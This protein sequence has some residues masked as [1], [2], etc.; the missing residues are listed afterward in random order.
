METILMQNVCTNF[1]ADI[2]CENQVKICDMSFL[3]LLSSLDLKNYSEYSRL[4]FL[5]IALAPDFFHEKNRLILR[6]KNQEFEI[7]FNINYEEFKNADKNQALKMLAEACLTATD[8][9]LAK[10]KD[11]RA[12]DFREDLLKIF[13][14]AGLTD[15]DLTG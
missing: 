2:S 4:T 8:Q 9:F 15:A 3:R 13:S 1:I 7:R 5:F 14:A 11:F 10:R 6:K 12:K